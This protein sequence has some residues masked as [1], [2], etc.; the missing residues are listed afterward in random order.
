ME[1]VE[2]NCDHCMKSLADAGSMPTYRICLSSEKVPNSGPYMNAVHVTPPI[3]QD[4]H[5]CNMYCLSEWLD[6]TYPR[7][8]AKHENQG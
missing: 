3:Q 8:R 2:V 5:F 6:K 4:H 1:R 7:I